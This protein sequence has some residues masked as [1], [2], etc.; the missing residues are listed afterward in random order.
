MSKFKYI[1][2]DKNGAETTGV[3]SADSKI[4][5]M[6]MVR[7]QGLL[8]RECEEAGSAASKNMVTK[9]EKEKK[10]GGT[11]TKKPVGKGK[12]GGSISRRELMLFTIKVG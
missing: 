7:A 6:E 5:A 4:A 1:A 3:I 10:Q 9:A 8:V 12:A 2:L 11:K